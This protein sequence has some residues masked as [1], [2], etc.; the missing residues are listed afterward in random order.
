M[1]S[2]SQLFPVALVSAE[3]VQDLAEDV[4]SL[5]P[6]RSADTSVR[7]SLTRVT[8]QG[9]AT[10]PRPPIVLLHGAFQNRGLWLTLD[11]QGLAAYLARQGYDVWLPELRG[12]G[13]TPRNQEYEQT[14]AVDFWKDDLPAINDFIVEQT[15]S[16]PVWV[17]HGWSAAVIATAVA[18]ATLPP[19]R[20]GGVA[21]V[22]PC[23]HYSAS[24]V[25]VPGLN[26]LAH[27]RLR[28]QRVVEGQPD[29]GPEVEP[30]SLIQERMRWCR[31]G[32]VWS[33]RGKTS[34]WQGVPN[35]SAPLAVLMPQQASRRHQDDAKHLFEQWGG[36]HKHWF[37]LDRPAS[38]AGAS[39]ESLDFVAGP[40][41]QSGV[42]P[43]LAEWLQG[44]NLKA[45]ASMTLNRREQFAKT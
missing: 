38:S 8:V 21:L 37:A 36:Q 14:R 15:G 42:W 22:A 41:A 39:L 4:Y 40:E 30:Y 1:R 9:E 6:D 44:L 2:S 11:A 7:L 45:D 5:K 23:L 27:W 10:G 35:I 32:G 34:A 12:H 26:L 43:T 16:H 20:V 25:P 28:R 31:R 19:D 3:L 29:Q 18:M 33:R 13:L 17:G 24:L